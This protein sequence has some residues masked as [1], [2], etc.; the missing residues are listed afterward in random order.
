MWGKESLQLGAFTEYSQRLPGLY[1]ALEKEGG[2]T[3]KRET[4]PNV[5]TG[6]FSAGTREGIRKKEPPDED[7]ERARPEGEKF[8]RG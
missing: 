7:P 5:S 6:P 1:T 4:K 8:I 3:L 2:G